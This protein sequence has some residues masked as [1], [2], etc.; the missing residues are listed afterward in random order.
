MSQRACH[1][2][3]AFERASYVKA[4]AGYHVPAQAR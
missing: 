1:D 2:P 3:T 4:L